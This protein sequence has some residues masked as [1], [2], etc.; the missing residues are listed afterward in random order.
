M[1]MVSTLK[2]KTRRK[3]DFSLPV[4]ELVNCLNKALDR[5]GSRDLLRYMR[6]S[7][8]YCSAPM[9]CL[10]ARDSRR[11]RCALFLSCV[12]RCAC[13]EHENISSA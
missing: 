7:F 10:S 9:F 8:P 1:S 5:F 6:Q 4:G 2:A 13:A 12:R 11:A 3:C